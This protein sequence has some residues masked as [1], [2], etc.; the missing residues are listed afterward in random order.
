MLFRSSRLQSGKLA[1]ERTP[2]DVSGLLRDVVEASRSQLKDHTLVARLPTE[3]WASLD[4]LRIEQVLTNLID[5]AIKYSPDGGQIDVV[6]DCDEALN[7][8][9]LTVRDH[10]VGVPPEHRA[11]IFDRFYQAHAGGPL[12]SMAGMGLGLYISRQ[13]VE[14]HNGSIRAEFPD[15][16]GTRFVVTLPLA[17]ARIAP[18]SANAEP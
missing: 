7:S 9:V 1:I 17:E 15:D 6:L 13:I 2:S 4:P 5:N 18:G 10:G 3:L 14:L 11:H 8:I 16:G 12:T